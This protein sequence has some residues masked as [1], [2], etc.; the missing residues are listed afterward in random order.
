MF[1]MVGAIEDRAIIENG[2]PVA[3]RVLPVRVSF[4]ERIEDGLTCQ[5]AIEVFEKMVL[6]PERYLGCLE[7]DGSDIHPIW[8]QTIGD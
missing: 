4:D 1:L 2:V 8:P 7:E 3:A 6:D 5:K